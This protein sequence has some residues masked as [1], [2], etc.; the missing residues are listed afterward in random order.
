VGGDVGEGLGPV[1]LDPGRC[2]AASG[3]RRL[4]LGRRTR[5]RGRRRGCVDVHGSGGGGS[6]HGVAET[7]GLAGGIGGNGWRLGAN[8]KPSRCVRTARRLATASC[9][10]YKRNHFMYFIPLQQ[11]F[12]YLVVYT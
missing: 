4:A 5:R 9:T 8:S 10:L 7:L 2:P 12:V 6:R 11:C 1:L 3:E